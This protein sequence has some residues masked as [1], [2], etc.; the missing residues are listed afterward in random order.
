MYWEFLGYLWELNPETGMGSPRQ[1][2]EPIVGAYIINLFPVITVLILVPLV[3]MRLFSEEHRSGTL[4]MMFTA[5]VDE[6]VVVLSKFTAALIFFLMMWMP[7]ALY[8]VD[9]R[10]EGATHFDYLPLLGFAVALVING[11]GFVSMG[12]FFSSLTRNQLI[13]AVFTFVG[14]LLLLAMAWVKD[15][16]FVPAGVRTA[17]EYLGFFEKWRNAVRGKLA[18]RDL[19][20]YLSM[21]IFWLFLTVKVLESRKWR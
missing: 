19:I 21:T 3:T 7:W 17:M 15:L 20:V 8:L 14:M 16:P 18:V 1:L 13:A 4:E 12:L 6:Q 9:L 2:P 5:P 10:A 11:A